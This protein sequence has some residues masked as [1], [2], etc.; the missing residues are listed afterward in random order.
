MG[1]NPHPTGERL[2]LFAVN[3]DEIRSAGI[4]L[5]LAL[6]DPQ[7]ADVVRNVCVNLAEAQDLIDELLARRRARE[8]TRVAPC[9][10]PPR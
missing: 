10:W 1:L 7:E 3:L 4:P 8:F 9:A 2:A 5:R 6:A